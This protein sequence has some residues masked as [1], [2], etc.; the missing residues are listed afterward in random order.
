MKKEWIFV[1]RLTLF[2]TLI[3]ITHLAI[4][5]V[6]PGAMIKTGGQYNHIFAFWILSFLLDFSFPWHN[7]GPSKIISLLGYG[8]FIEFIQKFIPS[9]YC[10][11]DDIFADLFGIFIYGVFIRFFK[12]MPIAKYRYPS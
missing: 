10:S 2:I 6:R 4:L 11:L 12:L 1:F 5:P 8:F 3:T 9:R 7:F